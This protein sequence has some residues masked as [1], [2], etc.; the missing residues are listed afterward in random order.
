MKYL[1]MCVLS[2]VMFASDAQSNPKGPKAK[3]YKPWLNDNS[4]DKPIFGKEPSQLQGPAFKNRKIWEENRKSHEMTFSDQP[5]L[6]GPAAKNLK[7]FQKSRKG[8]VYM[9]GSRK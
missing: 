3:N 8:S 7:P 1:I 5:T 4:V 6:K 2:G 9:A